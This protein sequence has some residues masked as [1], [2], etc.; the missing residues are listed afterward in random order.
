MKI[1][2]ALVLFR[3]NRDK[4]FALVG[5]EPFL[6][7]YFVQRVRTLS[8]EDCIEFYPSQEQDALDSSLSMFSKNLIVLRDF[9]K[10]NI[11]LFEKM[12]SESNF[13]FIFTEKANLKTRTLTDILSRC[14]LVECSKL[15]EYGTEYPVWI[16]VMIEDAGYRVQEGVAQL[17]YSRVGS[18]LY[19]IY[20]ELEKL[21]ILKDDLLITKEDVEK[22]VSILA[23][24]TFFELFEFLIKRDIRRVLISF[25]SFTRLQDNFIDLVGFLA[26]YL[27]KMYRVL[28][29]HEKKIDVKDIAEIVGIHPFILKTKYLSHILSLGR[30]FVA[31]RMEALCTVD[32]LLRSFRGDKRI[33]MERYFLSF[34]P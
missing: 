30:N 9:D 16:N 5:N 12:N 8:K 25:E 13:I 7:D 24:S 3:F 26:V 14:T 31:S 29:L 21:F 15:K 34:Q 27:E 19:D 32:M 11:G 6:K 1:S 23:S 28:L 4:R 17:L 10:M 18:N 2:E 33:I 22:Y 20:H